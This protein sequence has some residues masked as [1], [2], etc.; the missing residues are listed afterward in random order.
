MGP[1]GYIE[2][3]LTHYAS[4]PA[5][6][7]PVYG[8]RFGRRA[9][10]RKIPD[11]QPGYAGK[12]RHPTGDWLLTIFLTGIKMIGDCVLTSDGSLKTGGRSSTCPLP[13]SPI[14]P[15]PS[16][17]SIGRTVHEV[18]WQ[19]DAVWMLAISGS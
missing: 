8:S 14:S 9:Q 17:D 1:I 15:A 4:A 5:A 7:L 11:Y 12:L 16:Y 2:V 19:S 6:Q 3:A 13:I 18:R 10:I